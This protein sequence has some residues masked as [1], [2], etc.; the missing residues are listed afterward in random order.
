MQLIEQ[1]FAILFEEEKPEKETNEVENKDKLNI[2]SSACDT[3]NYCAELKFLLIKSIYLDSVKIF[4]AITWL[5]H[6]VHTNQI[7]YDTDLDLELLVKQLLQKTLTLDLYYMD[8]SSG[9][10]QVP[11]V[12][13]FLNKNSLIALNLFDNDDLTSTSYFVES[14]GFTNEFIQTSCQL[15][16]NSFFNLIKSKKSKLK[17][18]SN[19]LDGL[20]ST[21]YD[22]LLIRSV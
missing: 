1:N 13:K 7:D 17:Y 15:I 2:D 9:E 21:N 14:F 18:T 5:L 19:G 8:L 22:L 12:L 6:M 20:E 11:R 3:Q 16:T 10:K 4:A